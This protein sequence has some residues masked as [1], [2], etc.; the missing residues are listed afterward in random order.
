LGAQHFAVQV[1]ALDVA[2]Q[3]AVEAEMTRLAKSCQAIILI[4]NSA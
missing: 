4:P 2:D 1:V 3:L